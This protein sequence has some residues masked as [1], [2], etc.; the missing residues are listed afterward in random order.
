MGP[1]WFESLSFYLQILDAE[2]M[3][4]FLLNVFL[5]AIALA[6]GAIG[7]VGLFLHNQ[8]QKFLLPQKVCMGLTFFALF[9]VVFV[10][11]QVMR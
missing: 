3:A 8:G 10:A 1:M 7:G 9:T 4:T 11:M 2:P 5:L 6:C